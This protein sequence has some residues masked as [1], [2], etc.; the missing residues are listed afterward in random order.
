MR[1]FSTS[2]SLAPTCCSASR[3]GSTRSAIAFWRL[4]SSPAG[5]LLELAHRGPGPDRETTDCCAAAPRPTA[6][7]R[8][9]AACCSASR[10]GQLLRRRRVRSA[11]A[12]AI[13]LACASRRV[14]RSRA[15]P[16]ALRRA[17]RAARLRAGHRAASVPRGG[18]RTRS[19]GAPRPP[20]SRSRIPA[21][22]DRADRS[23]WRTERTR[24]DRAVAGKPSGRIA[25]ASARAE[26]HNRS[27]WTAQRRDDASSPAAQSAISVGA[28][29]DRHDAATDRDSALGH[30]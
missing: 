15:V 7:R 11:S 22:P 14:A 28:V 1:C 9:R 19:S 17:P 6:P 24:C 4:S 21:V 25:A 26:C 12:R 18:S 20:A 16:R 5:A 13:R 27:P 29:C 2:S 30:R 10:A 3:I 8:P 23:R